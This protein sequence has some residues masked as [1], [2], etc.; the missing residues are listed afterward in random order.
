MKIHYLGTCSGT[1]PMMDMH[2]QSW[3]LETN[4]MNYWFDAGENSAHRAYTSGIDIT[5]TVALFVSHP[6]IDHI[7]G[8]PLIL[9]CML[10]LT[11][12]FKKTLIRDNTLRIYFPDLPLLDAIKQVSF[13][14]RTSTGRFQILGFQIEDGLL[15][16]DENVRVTAIHN[17]HMKEDGSNGWH[18][19]S[20]L[21]EVEGKRVVFSGDVRYP[22]EMIPLL[23]SG[24]D[25]LIM[26]TGHHDVESVMRFA[27][28][29]KVKMLRLTH[30]GRQ[31][32][33]NRDLYENMAKSYSQSTDTN[34]M[35]CY[36][37]ME[38]EL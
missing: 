24:C 6:H 30:H 15:F 23:D 32:L 8:L 10:K 31:I 33:E 13:A 14:G 36:D 37:G 35:L 3:I 28:E 7:G 27:V 2:H 5:K 34:I 25:L 38:Q 1:E 26:E 16:E 19:F 17:Q 20:F 12:H 11:G 29:H 18:A 22:E 21:I 4:G 9:Q